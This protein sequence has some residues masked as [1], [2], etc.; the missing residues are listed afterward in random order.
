MLSIARA[1]GEAAPLILIGAITGRL[2]SPRTEPGRSAQGKFTAM[3]IVIFGWSNEVNKPGKET[4]LTF[5]DSPRPRSWSCSCWSSFFNVAAI[6]LRNRFEKRRQGPDHGGDTDD[7]RHADRHEDA[8]PTHAPSR[9]GARS[10]TADDPTGAGHRRGRVRRRGPQRCYYGDFRAVRDVDLDDPPARDHRVHRAVGLRQDDGAALLQPDERPHR[11]RPSVE[12]TILYH[13]VDLYDPE[14][15]AGRGP[16]A[17]RDG[18]PEA[19]PVPE[20][21]LRQRRLRP[22]ARRH[23]EASASSTRSSSSRCA[24]RRCGTR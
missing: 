24:A 1:L 15:N 20:E 7:R 21:H 22:A 6:V 5:T 12:G 9:S 14:V 2:A 18:V 13:G 3:P 10:L 4:G 11:H 8:W 23:Q 17:D 19:E 16:A